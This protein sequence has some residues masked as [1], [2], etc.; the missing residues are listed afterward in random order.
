[1]GV[2]ILLISGVI[3]ASFASALE[4]GGGLLVVDL[5][6]LRLVAQMFDRER[7]VTGSKASSSR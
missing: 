3:H 6:A 2:I 7:L 5:V 4:F 1:V